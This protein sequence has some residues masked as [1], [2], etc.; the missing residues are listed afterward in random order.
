MSTIHELLD[1]TQKQCEALVKEMETFKSARIL[2]HKAADALES[3]CA[4]LQ[5]TTNA[6]APL[7]ERRIR[8]MAIVLLV[9]TG[10]NF[11]MFL[12]T[13]LVVFFRK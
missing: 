7:T 1:N 8:Q 4:A 2:N 11:L 5:A 6:I 12:T 3:T 10:L 13:V 9:V